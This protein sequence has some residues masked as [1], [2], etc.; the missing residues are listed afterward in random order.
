MDAI[1]V[2]ERGAP[3]GIYSQDAAGHD[4]HAS[5]S[6]RR[7]GRESSL[8]GVECLP[9][10]LLRKLGLGPPVIMSIHGADVTEA[11]ATKG[12]EQRLNRLVFASADL[13]VGCSRNLT[14]RLLQFCP[15]AKA[16]AVWNAST[17]PAAY[18]LR[19]GVRQE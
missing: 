13:V 6:Q 8:C 1:A 14:D 7:R 9:L 4:P 3:A 11:L 16:V 17:Q 2:S 12:W 15:K 19:R 5:I 10:I 18:S